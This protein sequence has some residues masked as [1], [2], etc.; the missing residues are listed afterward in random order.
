[1]IFMVIACRLLIDYKYFV[2]LSSPFYTY[3]SKHLS[4]STQI[5][6]ETFGEELICPTSPSL[7]NGRARILTEVHYA[8]NQV[9]ELKFTTLASIPG[10]LSFGFSLSLR[11]VKWNPRDRNQFPNWLYET[12]ILYCV[13]PGMLSFSIVGTAPSRDTSLTEENVPCCHGRDKSDRET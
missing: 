8:D 13:V 4:S 2:N 6:K 5:R 3:G 12:I 10:V 1:M 11:E 7:G 9:H